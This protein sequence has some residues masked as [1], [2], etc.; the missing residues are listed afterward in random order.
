MC[1]KRFA[2]DTGKVL[3]GGKVIAPK[4]IDLSPFVEAPNRSRGST[5]FSL[6]AQIIHFGDSLNGGETASLVLNL[7]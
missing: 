5:K 4:E 1:V 7:R 3:L 6:V 2:E